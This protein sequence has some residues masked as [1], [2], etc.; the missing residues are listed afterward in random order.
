MNTIINQKLP[1]PFFRLPLEIRLKIYGQVLNFE[2]PIPTS[3]AEARRSRRCH[4]TIKAP[5]P[6]LWYPSF[7]RGPEACLLQ[8]CRQI[9]EE[10]AAVQSS[11]QSHQISTCELDI[12]ITDDLAFPTWRSAPSHTAAVEYDLEVSLRLFDVKSRIP[13]F[14]SDGWIGIISAPLMKIL[15]DLIHNGPQFL[16]CEEPSFLAASEPLRFNAITINLTT[17]CSQ[18]VG[19]CD[20]YYRGGPRTWNIAFTAFDTIFRFMCMMADSGLLRGK[21][22]ELRIYS[23]QVGMSKAVKVAHKEMSGPNV[24]YWAQHGY[25]WGPQA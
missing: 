9:K 15:D 12:I 23:M 3:P 16:P 14:G 7:Y 10:V 4:R 21:V 25:T 2:S 24:G 1:S 20:M 17:P 8:V 22:K 11:R 18:G 13:L 6:S 5:S 19:P